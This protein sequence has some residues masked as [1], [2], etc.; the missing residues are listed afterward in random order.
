MVLLVSWSHILT[1]IIGWFVTIHVLTRLMDCSVTILIRLVGWSVA[2]I[3]P[4]H[5]HSFNGLVC[6]WCFLVKLSRL[7]DCS[8]TGIFWSYSIVLWVGLWL[9]FPGHTVWSV[10]GIFPGHTHSFNGLVC[11]W[12]YLV[13]L[14][15][16]MGWCYWHFLV[17]YILTRIIGWFVTIRVLTRL[18]GWHEIGI[19]RSN[20]LV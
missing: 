13:I 15:C 1:R 3:F 14:T 12:Y 10:T 18:M 8:V 5:I 19:Y 6:D 20:S 7:M 16:L 11:D 17:I 2:Y 9:V 4:G